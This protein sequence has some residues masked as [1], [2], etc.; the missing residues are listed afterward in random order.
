MRSQFNNKRS[1]NTW[2]CSVSI[3]ISSSGEIEEGAT[4]WMAEVMA[5]IHAWSECSSMARRKRVPDGEMSLKQK[6]CVMAALGDN[7]SR[8][9]VLDSWK[10]GY[11][12]VVLLESCQSERPTSLREV[13]EYHFMFHENA[14]DWE[15]RR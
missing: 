12:S 4:A 9:A 2:H 11:D 1:L 14:S 15:E 8:E 5:R 3:L 10:R 13:R 7:N 6:G